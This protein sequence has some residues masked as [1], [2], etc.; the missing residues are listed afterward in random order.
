MRIK[1][2]KLVTEFD[3]CFCGK[4]AYNSI[5]LKRGFG[6]LICNKCLDKLKGL[7]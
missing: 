5:E 6:F 1:R 4:V 2:Q 7:L 3:R